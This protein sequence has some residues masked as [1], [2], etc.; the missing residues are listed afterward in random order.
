MTQEEANA[1]VADLMQTFGMPLAEALQI[2]S[3]SA[4]V[5]LTLT[6][7]AVPGEEMT[8]SFGRT[9]EKETAQ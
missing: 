9:I 1:G 7:S 8:V 2:I 5:P 6:L 3:D 4:G